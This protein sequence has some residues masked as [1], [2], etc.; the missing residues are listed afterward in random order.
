MES[1]KSGEIVVMVHIY[2]MNINY[3]IT[4]KLFVLINI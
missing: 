2:S 4:L 3:K 1:E